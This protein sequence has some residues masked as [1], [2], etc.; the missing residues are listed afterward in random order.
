MKGI[1]TKR[2]LLRNYE[3]TDKEDLLK[4]FTD[5]EVMK[6]VGD[7]VLTNEEAEKLWKKLLEKFCPNGKRTIWAVF[8]KDDSRYVGHASLRPRPEKKEDWEVGFILRKEEWGKGFATE[9]SQKLIEFGFDELNLS[10]IFA[11]VDDDNFASINVLKK[12]GMKF[13]QYE[14]D[15]QGRFSVY[16]I[17]KNTER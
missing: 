12:S 15:K 3:E 7:G 14:F 16:S 6:H 4:L 9:I 10:E 11:T 2:L 5:K 17:S 8:A 13:K 1:E